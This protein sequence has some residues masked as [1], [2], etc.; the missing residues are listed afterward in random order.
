MIM[1]PYETIDENENF[2]R[3]HRHTKYREADIFSS[4]T[5]SFTYKDGKVI[6][7]ETVFEEI[8]DDPSEGQDWNWKDYE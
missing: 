3:T 8:D 1:G 6:N 4:A 5:S 2:L 7:Q